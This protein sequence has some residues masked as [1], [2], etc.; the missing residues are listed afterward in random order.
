MSLVYGSS[1]NENGALDQ[2]FDRDEL[3]TFVNNKKRLK[4]LY[5]TEYSYMR[6][7]LWE[8]KSRDFPLKDYYVNLK[9]QETHNFSVSPIGDILDIKD[10]FKEVDD[11]HTSI[12][13]CGDP[14]SGKTTL[15][16]KIA[17]DWAVDNS[18]NNYI[19]HF[20]IV[21]VLT[22][23]ELE[24]YK[25]LEDAVL[26]DIFET[27][28]PEMK[29]KIRR[30]N[31]NVLIILDE[32]DGVT[33]FDRTKNFLRKGSFG[34]FRKLTIIVTSRLHSAEEIREFVNF[35]FYLQE[36]T[37]E[38]QEEY[39]KLVFKQNVGK[40]Q[41]LLILLRNEFYLSL[42]KYPLFL[43]MLCCFHSTNRLENIQR[44]TD[45][46]IYIMQLITNRSKKKLEINFEVPIGKH[47]PLEEILVRLGKLIFE[48]NT[49]ELLY[50]FGKKQKITIDELNKYV[51]D[52]HKIFCNGLDFLSHCFDIDGNFCFDCIHETIEEFLVALY[53]YK[54]PE[55]PFLNVT[56]DCSIPRVTEFTTHNFI[57]FYFGLFRNERIPESCFNHLDNV[58]LSLDLSI[59][60]YNEIFN[61]EDKKIFSNT[62]KM[63]HNS[64]N[65]C[66][67]FSVRTIPSDFSQIYTI[68]DI[69][70]SSDV[71][72][73]KLNKLHIRVSQCSQV[74]IFIFLKIRENF[75]RPK[76]TTAL[77]YD[78]KIMEN[79][80]DILSKNSWKNFEIYICG[81][82]Q[83]S[84]LIACDIENKSRLITFPA[85]LLKAFSCVENPAEI[86]FDDSN[87]NTS[88]K[89]VK[90]KFTTEDDTEDNSLILKKNLF[91]IIQPYIKLFHNL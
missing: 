81:I 14:G 53:L 89:L 75:L 61:E 37:P 19:S 55:V 43:H 88:Y 25:K 26:E 52:R 76:G 54:N 82:F 27:S 50:P 68:V 70:E 13:V 34:I 10:I 47:F 87:L 33:S 28:E 79:I 17:Y 62:I 63:Y 16:K 15:C 31:L 74:E 46:Y 36:F 22:L 64:C 51:D 6:S 8:N 48:K 80:R 5:Q 23:T 24:S 44:K 65:S 60:I 77:K 2:I 41:T 21:A 90:L 1:D 18:S 39:A 73:R 84:F 3:E 7:L 30:A 57:T 38:Q 40:T 49:N 66:I 58:V 71:T 78:W 56:R 35:R 45:L 72:F 29:K 67:G 91:Q 85:Y 12:L 83:A 42:S 20:D 4:K 59:I 32:Y 86:V 11:G 69:E 9:L